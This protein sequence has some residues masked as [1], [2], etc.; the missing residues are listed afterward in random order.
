M[1]NECLWVRVYD[2]YIFSFSHIINKYI[3]FD[4]LSFNFLSLFSR[5][6]NICYSI[7]QINLFSIFQLKTPWQLRQYEHVFREKQRKDD[8]FKTNGIKWKTKLFCCNKQ[9]ERLESF[10][11]FSIFIFLLVVWLK[12][13]RRNFHNSMIR[14]WIFHSD[15]SI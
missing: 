14:T 7:E 15:V 9:W 12:W 1:A 4:Q 8:A 13:Q 6:Q 10:P 3:L 2:G 5:I 11:Y